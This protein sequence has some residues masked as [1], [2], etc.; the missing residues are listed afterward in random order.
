[1]HGQ[2][3]GITGVYAIEEELSIMAKDENKVAHKTDLTKKWQ[4]KMRG[5][6]KRQIFVKWGRGNKR[7]MENNVNFKE[8]RFVI[9][10]L[11]DVDDVSPTMAPKI[12]FDVA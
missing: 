2:I 3:G 4:T 11:V 5:R 12:P 7:E 10:N 8:M 9:R 1:M 6:I